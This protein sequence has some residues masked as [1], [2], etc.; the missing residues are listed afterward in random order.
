MARTG[1][2]YEGEFPPFEKENI[3]HYWT[4]H[5][6]DPGGVHE[7]LIAEGLSYHDAMGLL[8]ANYRP[9]RAG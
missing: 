9:K 5:A 1:P 7:V 4:G 2:L 6:T 8:I 3:G